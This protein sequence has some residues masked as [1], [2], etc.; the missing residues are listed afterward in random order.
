MSE[1]LTDAWRVL[2]PKA[3]DRHGPLQPILVLLTVVTGFVDSF[4][5]LALGH[6]FVANMTGNVVFLGFAGAGSKQFSFAS[7][8]LAIGV[9]VLGALGG[10]QLARMHIAHR[11]RLMFYAL[12]VELVLTAAAYFTA[13]FGG[14]PASD[15]QYP[16]I[17]LLGL[18]MGVQNATARKL[19]VPDLTTTV[20]TLTITGTA[21]DSRIVGGPTSK[22]GR[23]A[24]S[25]V[26][27]FVGALFGALLVLHGHAA[28]A[29]LCAVVLLAVVTV[30]A[31]R[32]ISSTGEWTKA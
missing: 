14:N 15:L 18:G 21:A 8:I 19:A 23:R 17:I 11:G 16:L 7:S 24:I 26:F 6:V 9:F 27:M 1:I 30:A 29:L 28:I 4:S 10:G 13:Q 12:L 32:M 2:K 3:D 25:I 5:Y 20:L 22:L 31:Q